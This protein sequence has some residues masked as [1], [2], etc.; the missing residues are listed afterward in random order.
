[1]TIRRKPA[2]LLVVVFAI[3]SSFYLLA[4]GATWQGV[5][6]QAAALLS[7]VVFALTV[8]GW[9]WWRGSAV[10]H[11]TALDPLLPLAALFLA[12]S[13]VGNLDAWRHIGSGLWFFCAY[14][15]VWYMMQDA[16]A[17]RLITRNMLVDVVLIGGMILVFPTLIQG[18]FTDGIFSGIWFE[19]APG[20][21]AFQRIRVAGILLN[22]NNLG[23]FML[24]IIPLLIQRQHRLTSIQ[25]LLNSAYLL[26]AG[27]VLWMS[28]SR[29]AMIGL[30]T[31]F[32]VVF[33]RRLHIKAGY[34]L[35]TLFGTGVVVFLITLN[36]DDARAA[37]YVHA[38]QEILQH[39][40]TGTGLF[41]FR[42]QN[43]FVLD[44]GGTM[45]YA[46][47]LFLHVISELGIPGGLVLGAALV[48]LGR[49]TPPD[50]RMQRWT[51]AAVWGTVMHQMVDFPV[52]MP[53]LALVFLIVL[54]L[55][56]PPLPDEAPRSYAR[57]VGGGA[58]ALIVIG[59]IGAPLVVR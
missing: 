37:I 14:I 9:L 46:H 43:P 38:A 58:V 55:A 2:Y 54:A 57:I 36:G 45:L 17:N 16:L 56:I 51:Y 32:L 1:M 59:V 33:L 35:L 6:T 53:A 24:L 4:V 39:P 34:L 30:A 18:M 27:I 22:P 15:I 20:R 3:A 41:T 26:I 49:H 31:A 21:F 50:D 40:V 52:M 42:V 28:D 29:G 44:A 48:S 23:A 7:L 8:I 5:T 19:I 11:R 47:N 10:W 12:I 13:S 25:G